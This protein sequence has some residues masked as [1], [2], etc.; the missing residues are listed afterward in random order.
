MAE[1]TPLGKLFF[2]S[3]IAWISKGSAM[4]F[5]I[6]GPPEHMKA[7]AKAAFASKNYQDELNKPEATIESVMQK[8]NEKNSAAKEY[9]QTT[10]Y[11][12]PL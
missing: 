4:P 10:G 12:F 5:S 11:Q 1:L 8:L 9:E 6:E 3:L 2:G 7:L